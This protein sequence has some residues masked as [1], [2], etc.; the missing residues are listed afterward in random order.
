MNIP[1]MKLISSAA[2]LMLA[3]GAWAQ[4][5]PTTP[6]ANPANPGPSTQQ[7]PAA[8]AIVI[9]PGVLPDTGALPPD[10][11]SGEVQPVAPAI[12]AQADAPATDVQLEAPAAGMQATPETAATEPPSTD[13]A[14]AATYD[15]NLPEEKTYGDVS[16]V[17]GGI[18]YEQLPAFKEARSD[19]PLGIEIYQKN[20]A[21]SE[22]TADADVKVIN[23]SGDVVLETKAD[24]PF[25]LAKVPPGTYRVEASLNGKT[26]K[27]KPVTVSG[28]RHTRTMLVFP[29]GTD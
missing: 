29:Q 7:A 20:G 28:K 23:R 11:P 18:T 4:Q 12:G 21:K 19:Y 17:S 3:T 10:V 16:Y 25:V 9:P 2:A 5:D 22:F 26:V 13:S 6:L 15:T 8:G 14:W 1:K 24:G 27:S